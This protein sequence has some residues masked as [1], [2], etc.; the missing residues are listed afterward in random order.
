MQA[1]SSDKFKAVITGDPVTAKVIY[2]QPLEFKPKALHILSTNILPSFKGGVDAGLE[3]RFAVIPFER[4]IPVHER[5]PL[6]AKR[7]VHEE[8]NT[9]IS[10]AIRAAAEVLRKGTYSL[11]VECIEAIEE[12]FIEV[13]QVKQWLEEGGLDR[14]VSK[15][16]SLL[17]DIYQ[18]FR[19]EM[20][21]EG[22]SYIPHKRRFN[23]QV[24]TFI[25]STPCWEERR[26]AKGPK[27][28][29]S[30]LVTKMTKSA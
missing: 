10:E 15:H 29:A 16:G 30:D 27:V 12:W 24:R 28:F 9:L 21:D 7:I 17:L 5:I 22:V 25:D 11:P 8:G 20:K 13:D 6:I 26:T 1:I 19:E 23:F 4:T 3:R 14:H 2:Q 18:S